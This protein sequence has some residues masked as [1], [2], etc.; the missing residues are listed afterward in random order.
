MAAAAIPGSVSRLPSEMLDRATAI[1]S[2]TYETGRGPCEPGPGETRRWR[3]LA[4]FATKTV[5]RGKVGAASVGVEPGLRTSSGDAL[6]AG[7]EY[8]LLLRP[9]AQS[10]KRLAAAEA[11]PG[12]RDVIPAG[13]IVAIVEP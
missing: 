1:V 10:R 7:R 12:G 3:L 13:E 4:R 11:D 8:I 6:V 2:G 5:Y 9:S